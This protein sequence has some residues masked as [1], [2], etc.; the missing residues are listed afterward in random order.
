MIRFLVHRPIAVLVSFFALLLLGVTAYLYLPT[1]LL[2]ESDIPEIIVR[3]SGENLSAEEVEQQLATPIRNGLLQLHGLER[4]ESSASEGRAA[5]RVRFEAGSD[6]SLRFIEVNEKV[7]MAMNSLPREAERPLVVKMGVDDI[8]VFQLSVLPRDSLATAARLVAVST[9]VRET[10]TRRIEQLAEVAMVDV[11]GLMQPQVQIEPKAGYL[12]SLGLDGGVLTQAFREN[13]I[14]LGNIQVADGHYRYFLKFAADV[15]SLE[16]LRATPVNINGRVF[17]LGE[18][19]TVTLT[20]AEET[21]AFYSDGTRAINLGIIKQPSARME[22]L[23]THFD[24]LLA[25]MRQ[26]YPDL[27]F[28]VSQDQTELL[29]FALGNLWQD[30]WLG[31]VCAALLMLV[32]IRK[33]KPALLIGITIPVSL[34]IS[35]LGFF[36]LGISINI[37]SLGG[38]ILGLGMIIDNSIVVIDTINRY[39]DAGLRVADAAIEGTNEVI[40]PLI[41]SVL[42]NC[43]VF[44][45]LIFLSGLA[46][47]IFFDQALSVIIGVVASLIVALL[48]LP[49]LYTLVYPER[50]G[51][52]RTE[53]EIKARVHV[54]GWYEWGLGLVFRRPVATCL[55]VVALLAMSAG[56]FVSLDKARLPELTRDDFEASIDWNEPIDVAENWE[57][58]QAL[59]AGLD[60]SIGTFNAWVGEQQ[61]VFDRGEQQGQSQANLYIQAAGGIDPAAL[62]HRLPRVMAARFPQAT[63]EISPAQ[64]AFEAVFADRIAPLRMEVSESEQGEM[65][66]PEETLRLVDSLRR[67]LPHARIGPVALHDKV[68]IRMDAEQAARYGIGLGELSAKIQSVFRPSL[69]DHFQ[70]GQAMVPIL[71]VRGAESDVSGMLARSFIRK[72]EDVD[73]PLSALVEMART[74]SYRQ[75]MAGAQ[76]RYYPVAIHTDREREDLSTIQRLVERAFPTL[77]VAFGG[78][79]FDN[80]ALLGEMAFI[81]LVSVLLLYFILAAQFESLVQPL[82]ILAELPIAISGALFALYLA[83][84]SINLMSL[85]G[86]V[87]MSG[88]IIN[89]SILKID[90]INRLRR[91][92]VP[93]ME[94]I[95]EGGHKRLKPIVM[96]TLTSIGALAPTLFM[97]DLGSELQQPL[98]LTL[99]GGMVIGLF[100]SL[101]FVPLLYWWVYRKRS[102]INN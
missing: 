32:F 93:L 87:V 12:E 34:L 7:D 90:A 21:G 49:P 92:G 45:P 11:T 17:R 96:I 3:L 84:N 75:I 81:L 8:P 70:S 53:P 36:L 5:V 1:S 28:V 25:Q 23:Q 41:T 66:A 35:Q 80:R 63:V 62:Q 43:A 65:P 88:L 4:I 9:F 30:L 58:L 26:A 102:P 71:L 98:A 48:L 10:I 60:D 59:L 47:A 18:L 85:I 86:V 57:R 40:R 6:I 73:I 39:R 16:S 78:A 101:F 64:N 44:I 100:V 99:I 91:E 54:T 97:H 13:E 31:G 68:L 77:E 2:P 19:A 55:V 56:L 50:G 74:N 20:H 37:I 52:A 46:G 83:G 76:G 61:Y 94:A 72:S 82:F 14:S 38:L 29:A 22:D 33:F 89:D 15:A 24:E 69:V 79:Y 67:A 95:Y 42:T 51:G 27:A